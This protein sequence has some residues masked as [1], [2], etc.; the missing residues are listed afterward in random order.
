MEIEF[1]EQLT[2]GIK[3]NIMIEQLLLTDNTFI[4]NGGPYTFTV[5]ADAINITE[6]KVN[7]DAVGFA[8]VNVQY[9]VNKNQL[10]NELIVVALYKEGKMVKVQAISNLNPAG[11][12]V[13]VRFDIDNGTKYTA[14]VYC[15]D[16]ITVRNAVSETVSVGF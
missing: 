15:W 5:E 12:N 4:K 2:G 9:A 16:S 11:D 8:D 13:N 6:V 1:T 3:C 14:K 7:T 10:T